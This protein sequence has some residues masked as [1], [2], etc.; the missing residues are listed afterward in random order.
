MKNNMKKCAMFC[1]ESAR[2]IELPYLALKSA[3]D[4]VTGDADVSGRLCKMDSPDM[5]MPG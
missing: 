1:P 3:G 2:M 5:D 4:G